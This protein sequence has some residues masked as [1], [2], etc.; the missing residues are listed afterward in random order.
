M[1]ITRE[2]KA[3][4]NFLIGFL[5]ITLFAAS[6]CA[7][8]NDASIKSPLESASP[9]LLWHRQYGG[10]RDDA[11]YSIRELKNGE[12]SRPSRHVKFQAW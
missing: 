5:S 11:A 10:E 1:N 9:A 4:L 8:D 12:G 6:L 2:S 7:Q 3:G